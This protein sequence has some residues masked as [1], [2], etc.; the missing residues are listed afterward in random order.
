MFIIGTLQLWW[1]IGKGH[2]VR[3]DQIELFG[4][5]VTPRVWR[6]KNV[7]NTVPTVNHGY[8]GYSVTL[9]LTLTQGSQTHPHGNQGVA[10]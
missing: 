2:V 1:R 5:N 10:M 7:E 8:S 9:T 4:I 3:R 6:S